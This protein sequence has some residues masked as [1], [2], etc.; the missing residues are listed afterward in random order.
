MR[1]QHLR[2][3]LVGGEGV[4]G[5]GRRSDRRHLNLLRA[6]ANRTEG[7]NRVPIHPIVEIAFIADLMENLFENITHVG[8]M[9]NDAPLCNR[10]SHCGL[11][12][13]RRDRA[14]L[15]RVGVEIVEAEVLFGEVLTHP[16]REPLA[17]R[18]RFTRA[19]E[20]VLRHAV[21][22]SLGAAASWAGRR[23]ERLDLTQLLR[24]EVF[25]R[26][27]LRGTQFNLAEHLDDARGKLEG[28][29][30]LCGHY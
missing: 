15:L 23:E 27:A 28:S 19:V 12:D 5:R 18:G 25:E 26:D 2:R 20:V 14:D 22:L 4:E 10:L 6:H 29:T 30:D 7:D 1:L 9:V 11:V 17:L 21:A 16:G 24:A 8:R 3:D 13:V